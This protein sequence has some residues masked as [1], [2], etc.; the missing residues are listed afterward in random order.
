[1]R[2]ASSASLG[3]SRAHRITPAHAGS[4][5]GTL[6]LNLGD[7]DHPRACGEHHLGHVGKLGKLGSPPR[8]RGALASRIGP[9][10]T[11]RITPAHAGSMLAST[12]FYMVL[13]DH[14]RAC[15]EH[16]VVP[17]R[18]KSGRGSPP[19]MRGAF[20]RNR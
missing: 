20:G 15:G 2:G 14:P 8:M 10:N 19:R 18:H 5:D 13:R 4:I 12:L 6:W 11:L 16:L 1:M 7:R 9:A 3:A 17:E